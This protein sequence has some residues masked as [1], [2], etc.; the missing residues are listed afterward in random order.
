MNLLHTPA[1]K[2]EI[3]KKLFF[4]GYNCTQ[5]VVGAF[6]DDYEA[7]HPGCDRNAL[8]AMCQPL[9]G[10]MGR[11]REVCGGVS[12]MFLVLG[13][14][15]G[16]SDPTDKAGKMSVY[17]LVQSCAGEY[18]ETHGSIICRELLANAGLSV[19]VGGAPAERTPEFYRKR[20]CPEIICDCAKL[21]AEKLLSV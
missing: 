4:E 3:A 9:G 5:A 20:P 18:K 10:G 8:L 14:F 16:T 17:S 21:V 13:M 19:S 1:E 7:L 12:G 11:L 15:C 6:L 2:G